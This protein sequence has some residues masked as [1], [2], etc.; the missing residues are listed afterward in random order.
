MPQEEDA[1]QQLRAFRQACAQF[2]TGVT[3][4]T[5]QEGDHVHAMTANAFMSVSLE[6][7]LVATALNRTA[8]MLQILARQPDFAISILN[9]DQQYWSDKFAGR[10][11]LAAESVPVPVPF[12]TEDGHYAVVEHAA[13]WFLCTA[14]Q[15]V[16]AGD[17][18]L[19][20]AQ[21]SRFRIGYEGPKPLVFFG[22]RYYHHLDEE[23]ETDWL[24]LER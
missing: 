20:V 9:Q 8:K 22:G 23:R 12:H 24:L 3:V 2:V 15:E 7:L 5:A 11:V 21:V 6:P 1:Q 13:A 10:P 16:E 17:H 4:L 19:I 18:V 14:A